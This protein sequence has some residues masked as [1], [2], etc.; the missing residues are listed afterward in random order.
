MAK[1]D[2]ALREGSAGSTHRW[3]VRPGLARARGPVRK[4][5][6]VVLRNGAVLAFRHPHAGLQLVKGTPEPGE[7][8]DET[9]LRELWEESGLRRKVRR[10]LGRRAIGRP[11]IVWDFVLMAPGPAPDR[12]S[13]RCD[14]GGG[15]TFRFFWHPLGT[16]PGRDWHPTMRAALCGLRALL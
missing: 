7:A 3:Q 12:W 2:A 8:P 6:P 9:A 5:C 11:G 13:H 15:L 10:T 1:A 16:P 4:V 14:D